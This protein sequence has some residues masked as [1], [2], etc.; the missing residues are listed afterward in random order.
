M[1]KVEKVQ[2]RAEGENI[3]IQEYYLGVLREA[4]YMNLC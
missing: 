3:C 4:E 2:Q 1:V